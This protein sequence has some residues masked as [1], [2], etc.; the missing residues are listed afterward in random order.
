[1]FCSPLLQDAFLKE[2]GKY[3]VTGKE[4]RKSGDEVKKYLSLAKFS[5]KLYD[6]SAKTEKRKEECK[7]EWGVSIWVRMRWSIWK[8]RGHQG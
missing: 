2:I 8:N 4:G 5:D 7:E 6:V 3:S 1:M